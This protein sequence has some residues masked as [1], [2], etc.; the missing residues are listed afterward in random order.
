[1]QCEDGG[2][3]MHTVITEADNSDHS[4][5]LHNQN[6]TDWQTDNAEHKAQIQHPIN[7]RAIPPG[8]DK[9]RKWMIRGHFCADNASRA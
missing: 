7:Y 2:P 4:E 3:W 6:D 8:T 1:M 5:T 9:E